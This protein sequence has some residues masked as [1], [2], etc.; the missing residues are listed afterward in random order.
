[1]SCTLSHLNKDIELD[2]GVHKS[3]CSPSLYGRNYV[4]VRQDYVSHTSFRGKLQLT[5]AVSLDVHGVS[6]LH[7]TATLGMG[8]DNIFYLQGFSRLASR[9]HA[10]EVSSI[11]TRISH[12]KISLVPY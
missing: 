8:V 3:D 11:P 12:Q 2:G 7:Q 10:Y 6:M 9:I 1:M 5:S 4:I